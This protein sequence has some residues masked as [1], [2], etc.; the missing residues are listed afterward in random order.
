[1]KFC[2][3]SDSSCDLSEDWTK[4]AGVSVVPFYVSL[5]GKEYLQEGKQIAVT[6]FYR[7]MEARPDCFPKTSMPSVQDYMDAFLPAVK[8]GLPVLCICLTRNFS[9]SMEAAA[10]ARTALTEDFPEAE[11]EVMDSRLATGLQ[12]LFVE[13]TVAEGLRGVPPDGGAGSGADPGVGAH[14]FHHEGAEIS[15]AGRKDRQGGLR[16]GQRAGD[17]AAAAVLRRRAGADGAVPG[18][19]AFPAEG[20]GAAAA[21][22]GAGKDRP[23]G[24]PLRHGRRAAGAGVS[25]VSRGS[26]KKAGRSATIGVHTGP[27]PVGAGFLRKWTPEELRE[28][29]EGADVAPGCMRIRREEAE[30][31]EAVR[32]VVQAAF[33]GVERADGTEQDLVEELRKSEAFLPELSL[34]AEIDGRIAGHILFT[35]ARAGDTPVLALAPLSVLPEYQ[36]RGVGTALIREGHRIAGEL[37][38]GYSV[39]LGSETYYPRAGYRPAE[40]FG[41]EPPPGFPREN[42]MAY[43]IGENAPEVSGTMRYAEEF[44]I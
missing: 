28:E 8:E 34:V 26:E 25:G 35:K 7:E 11:I 21:V 19:E 17:Q 5:N 36:G 3:V 41:I 4:R 1:M 23:E 32:Q 13:E 2:I 24:L 27:Y 38:F 12:G 44:G 33:A 37:G 22:R 18:Q 16:G 9:G 39:V 10:N 6:D 15:G 31:Y 20:G 42:F 43:K 14:F 29:T 30:D 40:T